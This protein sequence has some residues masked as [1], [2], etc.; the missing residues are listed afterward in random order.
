[1]SQ[2]VLLNSVDHK[3]LKINLSR[4]ALLGDNLWF[5]ATFPL[6]FRSVQAH[7]P[8]FFQKDP[9]SGQFFSVAMFGFKQNENLFLTADGWDAAYIPLSVRRQ[10]FLIGQQTI[11]EDGVEQQQRVIHI[12]MANPRIGQEGEALFYEFGGNTPYLDEVGDMLETIHQ[13]LQDNADFV[14]SLISN[15]L[16]ES[17]TLDITLDDGSQN[18]MLGFYTINEDKLA[19]LSAEILAQLHHKGHLQAIYM[20]LASHSNMRDLMQRKNALLPTKG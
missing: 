15:E 9:S 6:E 3:N 14:D 5:S 11:R 19:T 16:L 4:S 17:F 8:I 10:P 13:G 18:Q 20:A 12:D 2:H 7:Y 1:M